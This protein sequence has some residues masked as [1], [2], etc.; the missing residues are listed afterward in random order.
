M[1]IPWPAPGPAGGSGRHGTGGAS[2][3]APGSAQGHQGP[4]RRV[5]RSHHPWE[6]RDA[7]LP[8]PAGRSRLGRRSFWG[9]PSANLQV[10]EN[11]PQGTK[12]SNRLGSMRHVSDPPLSPTAALEA[13][14]GRVDFG[15]NRGQQRTGCWATKTGGRCFWKQARLFGGSW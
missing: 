10:L 4:G 1:Q 5:T 7:E 9:H 15:G 13:A 8:R 3:A 2:A 14:A 6:A 11:T 12:M